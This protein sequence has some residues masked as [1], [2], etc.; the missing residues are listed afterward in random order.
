LHDAPEIKEEFHYVRGSQIAELPIGGKQRRAARTRRQGG[1]M[2]LGAA[3]GKLEKAKAGKVCR[4]L[5]HF[6]WPT[7]SA[8]RNII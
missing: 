5:C 2:L 3:G 1:P 6:A 7:L 4:C 8:K